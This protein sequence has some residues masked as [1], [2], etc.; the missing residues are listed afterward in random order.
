M[1][2]KGGKE[3]VLTHHAARRRALRVKIAHTRLG[4]LLL[5]S[6]RITQADLDCA[7]EQQRLT[8]GRIGHILLRQNR[9][10]RG[11]IWGTL[12][13]QFST[14][15]ALSV[16]GLC[17]VLGGASVGLAQAQG[18]LSYPAPLTQIAFNAAPPRA[19]V[20]PPAAGLFGK[21]EVLSTNMS[22]FTKW[23]SVLSRMKDR[24]NSPSALE[25]LYA[26]YGLGS[27]DELAKASIPDRIEHIN[28]VV[29]KLTYV[30]DRDVWGKSDY[31]ATPRESAQKGVADCEDYAIAKYALLKAVGVPENMMRLA[32]VRDEQ[33]RIPHAILV[34]YDQARGPEILDNQSQY[35]RQASAI[36]WYTPLYSI[37]AQAWWRHI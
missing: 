7:L 29:N 12:T 16:I 8:G 13:Q 5:A 17:C 24:A 33:K 10:T 14:R 4:D 34:V 26:P 3:G 31:W 35:V 21:S 9:I 36:S 2:D 25:K 18:Q 19:A 27:L 37:N 30:E 22:A 6:G 15:L 28:K 32:I 23:T 11:D 20:A 1:K